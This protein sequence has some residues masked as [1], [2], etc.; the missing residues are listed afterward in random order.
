[1]SKTQD[2]PTAQRFASVFSVEL[3]QDTGLTVN[4]STTGIYFTTQAAIE[5]G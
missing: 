1:M 4:L 5:T 3:A 2:Q